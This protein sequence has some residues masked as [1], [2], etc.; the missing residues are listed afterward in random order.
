MLNSIVYKL[1]TIVGYS[2]ES[3]HASDPKFLENRQIV[4]GS[5]IN[6]ALLVLLFA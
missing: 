4:F 3:N 5:Q 2:V 1:F 6:Y